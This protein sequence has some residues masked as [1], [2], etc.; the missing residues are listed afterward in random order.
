MVVT[1]SVL[2]QRSSFPFD[3]G[4]S[5]VVRW[6][7]THQHKATIEDDLQRLRW[8]N[9]HLGSLCLDEI[10]PSRC[11]AIASAK[12]RESVSPATVNHYLQIIRTILR[13]AEQEWDWLDKAPRVRFRRVPKQR[14]R[15]LTQDEADR[16]L[17]A[18]PEHLAEMVRF[19][20]ATGLRAANGTGLTWSQADLARRVG[21][22]HADEAKD[23]VALNVPLND[24]AVLVLRR[25]VGKHSVWVFTYHDQ[26]IANP[27]GKA[28]RK[29]LDRAGIRAYRGKE[30]GSLYPTQ[31]VYKYDDFRWHDLRHTWASWHVMAG[32][33]LEV[34]MELGGWDDYNMARRYAHLAPA[35]VAPYARN[36]DRGPRLVRTFSGTP[37]EVK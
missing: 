31:A 11:E 25:Q 30:A 21:W 37:T 7:A 16:L 33:P 27:N 35:H 23:G 22:V 19:T 5:P 1:F 9:P 12:A 14:I 24:E 28:W 32:T 3:C 34:L 29:A 15:W 36:L 8:L 10:T 2:C 17:A 18:L 4:S 13:A 20:L 26:P 6:I